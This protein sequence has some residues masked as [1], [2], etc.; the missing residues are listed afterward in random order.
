MTTSTAPEMKDNDATR[1]ILAPID[2]HPPGWALVELTPGRLLDMKMRCTRSATA[3]T[4]C[5]RSAAGYVAHAALRLN[6]GPMV[7]PRPMLSLAREGGS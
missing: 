6:A 4:H 2:G 7:R 5:D 3:R 1:P